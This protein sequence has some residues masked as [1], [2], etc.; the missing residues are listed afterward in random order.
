MAGYWPRSVFLRV[1]GPRGK[2]EVY[3]QSHIGPTSS[4][5]IIV[6][7]NSCKS[8][9]VRN[10]SEKERENPGEIEE[11]YEDAILSNTWWSDRCRLITKN[12]SHLFE[13]FFFFFFALFTEKF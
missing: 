1:Y 9:K 5:V 7:F 10:T 3:N 12:I 2:F 6:L 4:N 8:L 13:F 11:T